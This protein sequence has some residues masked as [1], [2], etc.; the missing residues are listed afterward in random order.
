MSTSSDYN[1]LRL[2]APRGLLQITNDEEATAEVLE[3]ANPVG[4]MRAM[5]NHQQQAEQDLRQLLDLCGNM[6]DQT[7]RRIRRIEAAYNRLAHGAQSVY[8]QMEAKEQISG[9]WVR[10]ELMVAA[11]A[12]Q[13]FT[14]Q[15][16]EAIIERSKMEEMQRMHEAT[17]VARMHDAVA[18]LSE[19][20]LTRNTHLM[21]F[22]VMWKNGLL[23]ISRRWR[24]SRNSGTRTKDEWPGWNSG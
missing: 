18:F 16:W 23:T 8:E 24:H 11:N 17:Q 10:N 13:A 4:W 22:K 5:A 12:Y 1:M 3:I 19:A 14:R 7:D 15:V 2:E 21:E 6:M 20:N 9:D